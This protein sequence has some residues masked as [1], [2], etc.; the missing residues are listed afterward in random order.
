VLVEYEL[1]AFRVTVYLKVLLIA[2]LDD[3]DPY[4]ASNDETRQQ[5]SWC[6]NSSL[7]V[8]VADADVAAQLYANNSCDAHQVSLM[9]WLY[10]GAVGT[11][12]DC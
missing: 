7:Q 10:G 1:Y 4:T 12:I 3:L 2:R 5:M 8:S 9:T 11:C 6:W